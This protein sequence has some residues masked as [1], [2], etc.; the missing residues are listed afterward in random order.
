MGIYVPNAKMPTSCS[1]CDIG[2]YDGHCRLAFDEEGDG[3]DVEIDKVYAD[4]YNRRADFCPLL[5]T[6]NHGALVDL[7]ELKKIIDAARNSGVLGK[8][9]HYKLTKI[10]KDL[11]I[12]IP[13][14]KETAP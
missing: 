14:S 10:I 13:D 2:E 4:Y 5:L 1:R 12:V 6:A 8:M 3:L 11:P 9:A 7:D